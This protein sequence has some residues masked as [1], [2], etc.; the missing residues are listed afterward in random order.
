MSQ[1]SPLRRRN[2]YVPASYLAYFTR[3]CTREG[4]TWVYS[5]EDPLRPKHLSLN[6]VGLERNLYVRDTGAGLEDSTEV[7]LAESVEGPFARVLNRILRGARVG[8]IPGVHALSPDDR[9]AVA[10]F[11]SFQMLRTPVER[12]AMR[13]LG[14]LSTLGLVREN[15]QP[16]SEL[17][18]SLEALQ[19]ESLTEEAEEAWLASLSGLPQLRAQVEDW[20][21]RTRRNAERFAP[22]LTNLE[23]RIVCA[24]P[25]VQLVTCDMP[26]VCTRR[27]GPSGAYVLGGAFGEPDFEAT[28]AL[29]PR[30]FLLVTHIVED[31]AALRTEAFARS[32]RQRTIEYAN[33]W[34]YSLTKDE[35]LGAELAATPTPGYYIEFA[36][37]VFNVGDPPDEIERQIRE[38]GVKTL[39]FR[40]G[41]GRVSHATD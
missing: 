30:Y 6:S 8:L 18:R 15:L 38:S 11:L 31:E 27:T 1:S 26:L 23:W 36:G 5:R 41:V 32:V 14:Q 10:R 37:R 29:S 34:V 7:F 22:F 20:L 19:G 4:R 2:H 40:Y 39:R 16:A 12:D 13:W 28:L 25:S 35:H 17:R 3:E 33:R 24:P 9:L 21:P